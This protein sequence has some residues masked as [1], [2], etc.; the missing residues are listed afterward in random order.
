MEINWEE[1]ETAEEDEKDNGDDEKNYKIKSNKYLGAK[2]DKEWMDNIRD[3]PLSQEQKIY[4]KLVEK[5]GV[6][7][8][9]SSHGMLLLLLSTN[10]RSDNLFIYTLKKDSEVINIED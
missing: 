8:W 1:Y 9:Q 6:F 5:M 10:T 2:E 3:I 4:N 7:K